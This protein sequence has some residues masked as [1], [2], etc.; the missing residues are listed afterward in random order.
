M[1]V[2]SRAATSAALAGKTALDNELKKLKTNFANLRRE[3][4]VRVENHRT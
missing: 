1:V 3:V 2:D 4:D